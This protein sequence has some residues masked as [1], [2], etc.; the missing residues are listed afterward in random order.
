MPVVK[1]LDYFTLNEGPVARPLQ[2]WPAVPRLKGLYEMG[3]GQLQPLSP[4][5]S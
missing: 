2:P 4:G 3:Q 1:G 5:S